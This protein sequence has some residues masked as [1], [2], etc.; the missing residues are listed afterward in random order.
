MPAPG[1]AVPGTNGGDRGPALGE[2]LSSME[3]LRL[4]RS[5][6]MDQIQHKV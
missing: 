6:A 4:E 5:T 1:G 2:L 3:K